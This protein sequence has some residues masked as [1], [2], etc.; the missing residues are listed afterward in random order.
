MQDLE[1]ENPSPGY[2]PSVSDLFIT[3]FIIAIAILAAVFFALLPKNN[4]AS[5]KAIIVAVGQD[6]A[7]IRRP[8]NE[9][10]EILGLEPIRATQTPDEVVAAVDETCGK[11][12]ERIL[13]LESDI[14]KLRELDA[15]REELA[16]L[17]E[18]NR[19]LKASLQKLEEE[20]DRLLKVLR[21]AEGVDI[22]EIIAK[23]LKLQ[24]ENEEL[25]RRVFIQFSEQKE[26]YKFGKGSSSM[27]DKFVEGLR[28]DEFKRLADEIVARQGEGRV[29]VDTL[30]IIGHTDGLPF[31]GGGN[32]DQG[33]PDM[34]G[35]NRRL[36]TLTPGSNNDLGLLRALAVREQ[37]EAF[38]AK[39]PD[40]DVLRTIEIRCY[41]AGQTILPVAKVQPDAKDFRQDDKSARR[42]EMRLTR[43][44]SDEDQPA[45]GSELEEEEE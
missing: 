26:D 42:I 25:K 8:I 33:L 20:L 34:L 15:A 29:K 6:L 18:E 16:K 44:K 37:W 23:N 17:Q 30:E 28:N 3:L 7:K 32:L 4:V 14:K 10:R 35:G 40:K 41:S 1:D 19:A 38:I 5:E 36:S 43:L 9:L 45:P 2:W 27:G 39:H 31:S 22:D 13:T 24:K 21:T 11:A 12:G